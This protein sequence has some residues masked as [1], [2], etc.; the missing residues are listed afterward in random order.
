MLRIV[1]LIAQYFYPQQQTKV[2]NEGCA[3]YCHYRIMNTLH[4]TRQIGD[5]SFLEFLHSHTN[6]TRQPFCHDPSYGGINP[7]ALGFDMMSDITRIV[8]EPTEEDR[9]WFPEIAGAGDEM[10]V[11]SPHL[12]QLSR[13][14]FHRAIL[15][16][17]PH[18]QVA[19]VP[20]RR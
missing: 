3:T 15:E 13:R 2:M 11:A 5:G 16:P 17:K 4:E 1:R 6:A 9:V 14:Q 8:R 12:G 19:A 7:Y 10:A 20:Y 18:T